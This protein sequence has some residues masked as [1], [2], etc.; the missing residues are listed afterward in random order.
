MLITGLLALLPLLGHAETAEEKGFAIAVEVDARDTGYIN[1][2]A[3]MKMTLTNRQGQSSIREMRSKTL[4]VDGDGD[5]SLM[6]FDRPRDVKG[7]AMLTFTH[8]EG[9]DDQWLFLPA[10][11]RVKRIASN[12]KS[13]PF[14]GSEFAYEDLSSQEVEKYTYQYLRDDSINNVP[15]FV[16]E[17]YPTDKKSGYTRQIVWTHQTEYRAEKIEYFDR[18][19]SALKTLI[20]S[21]YKQYLDQ[22]WR[23]HTMSM[24]N[25]LTGKS[26]VL[27]FSDY[28][29]REDLNDRDFDKSSLKRAK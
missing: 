3:E 10:L 23:A 1:S 15:V 5:K 19:N 11:K 13:G 4:E 2:T 18:K 7:T 20:F 29:F 16:I 27:E 28:K 14:M 24:T 21:D 22:Y 9:A 25:H 12:N 17:R 6:I 8:K 26:T